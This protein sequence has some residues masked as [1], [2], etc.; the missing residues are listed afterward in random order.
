MPWIVLLVTVNGGQVMYLAEQSC[1]FLAFTVI[2]FLFNYYGTINTPSFPH[3]ICCYLFRK[4]IIIL[5]KERVAKNYRLFGVLLWC[6]HWLTVN[7]TCSYGLFKSRGIKF[8]VFHDCGLL[9]VNDMWWGRMEWMIGW[10]VVCLG[11]VSRVMAIISLK[12]G[13]IWF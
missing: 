6:Y 10:L 2:N 13:A 7:P 5:L 3:Y 9:S 4:L 12:P 8:W 11:V 1:V